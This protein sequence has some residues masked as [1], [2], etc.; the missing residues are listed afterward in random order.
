MAKIKTEVTRQFDA[1][2]QNPLRQK[3]IYHLRHFEEWLKRWEKSEF[4]EEMMGLLHCLSA[5]ENPITYN[6]QALMFLLELADGHDGHNFR[7]P[8]EQYDSDVSKNRQKLSQK[9]YQVLCLK[10]FRIGSDN[11][12]APWWRMFDHEALFQKVLWWLRPCERYGN[13]NFRFRESPSHPHDILKK[14][15][16]E[17]CQAG[18]DFANKYKQA[19]D[20]WPS[21][22][23]KTSVLAAQP[24]FIE[25]MDEMQWLRWLL[26]QTLDEACLQKLH[27]LALSRDDYSLPKEENTHSSR[28]PT[29]LEEAVWTGSGAAQVIALYGIKQ[30]QQAIFDKESEERHK[31]NEEE[32]RREE[33]ARIAQEQ[34]NL[35]D[36]AAELAGK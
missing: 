21:E 31:R 27:E 12:V 18:W 11:S 20:Y 28:K 3:K 17:F 2:E 32:R 16:Q 24:R 25:I 35:A 6:E 4:C 30:A 34:K 19:T 10:F 22:E 36:R 1:G 13:K 14:F 8:D 26:R 23:I 9:A 7:N 29:T 5:E 15:L 33:L